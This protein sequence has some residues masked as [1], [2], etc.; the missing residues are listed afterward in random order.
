MS[1]AAPAA[2]T[3]VSNFRRAGLNYLDALT[4]Q[5]NALR[6]VLKEPFKSESTKASAF[7]YRDF[8][9]ENGKEAAPGAWRGRVLW[10]MLPPFGC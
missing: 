1:A 6:R 8:T 2:R 9:Y 5:T 4:V 3:F 10:E 7:R